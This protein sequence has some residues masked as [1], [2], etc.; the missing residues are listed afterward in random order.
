MRLTI[1]VQIATMFEP[2][3]LLSRLQEIERKL[4]RIRKVENGPRTIDLD[5]LL[6]GFMILKHK[7]LTIPHERMLEREFVLR[8]L[9]K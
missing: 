7:D 8:P 2:L 3:E 6:Y 1:G 9:C 5:I 4:G